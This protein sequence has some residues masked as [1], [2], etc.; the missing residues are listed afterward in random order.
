MK[1]VCFRSGL[2]FGNGHPVDPAVDPTDT[3]HAG[4][5]VDFGSLSAI[6]SNGEQYRLDQDDIDAGV[7]TI[8][9]C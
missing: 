1:N 6:Q 9:Y 8:L 5:V 4:N 7:F 2:N 3:G